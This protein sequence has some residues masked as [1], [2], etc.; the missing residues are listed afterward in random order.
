MIIKPKVRGFIC[1]TTPRSV[2]KP[3]FVVRSLYTKAK[4]AIENGPRRCW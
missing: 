3:M 4:G 2:V 1:T